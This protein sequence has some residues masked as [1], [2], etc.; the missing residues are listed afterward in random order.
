MG[1]STSSGWLAEIQFRTV[2]ILIRNS[3]QGSLG[4]VN[5]AEMSIVS[6]M[7]LLQ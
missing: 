3:C 2:V 1:E 5:N 7:S 6:E 4:T